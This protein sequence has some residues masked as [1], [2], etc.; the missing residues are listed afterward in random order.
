MNHQL[1]YQT[2]KQQL[3]QWIKLR[4]AVME[5]PDPWR[6]YIPEADEA[7]EEPIPL[8]DAEELYTWYLSRAASRSTIQPEAEL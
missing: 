1:R 4:L 8:Q 6:T 2:A 3:P 7:Q 5:S